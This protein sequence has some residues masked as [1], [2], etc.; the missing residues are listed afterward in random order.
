MSTNLLAIV[1]VLPI[2]VALV[3]MVGLRWGAAKAMTVAWL[4][5]ALAALFVWHLPLLYVS[6]LSLQGVINAISVLIIVFGALLLLHTLQ[7]SGAMETIQYGMQNISKDMRIQAIII[8]YMFSAFVE[9]AAGFGT[10]AALAAPLLFALGFPPLAA[11]ILC[12]TLN[13]FPVTFGA[14]GTP[15]ITG[16][17]A[18]LQ[19]LIE[20]AIEQRIFQSNEHFFEAIG[21]IV[22]LMHIPMIFILPIFTLGFITRFFGPNRSWKDG[23]AAWKFCIF[24]AIAFS[25]P[26]LLVAWL[27]GPEIPS[28]AGG[29]IGL[30]IIMFGAQYGFCVPKEIWTFGKTSKWEK[31]WSGNITFNANDELKP[32]M[33]QFMAWLPYILIGII[34]VLTR[35]DILP[36]KELFNRHGVIFFDDIFGYKDVDE[37]SLK[38][39]Y[40][41]GTIPFM[42]IS[43]LTIFIHRMPLSKAAKAWSETFSKMKTATISLCASVA[44]VKIFQGS[45]NFTNPDLIAQLAK[46]GVNTHILS[47]PR[48]MAEAIAGIVGPIWPLFASYVGGLGSF[49]TGSNTVSDILF[50]QFQWDVAELQKL[51]RVVILAAQGVGGAMGNMICVHNIVAVCAVL[52]LS[53]REGDILKKTFW[54]F[55]LYGLSVGVVAYILIAIGYSTF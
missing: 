46:E 47:M 44:L 10:P 33:S 20:R 40:L 45:G 54:P 1:A 15:I 19:I 9:G 37:G 49:I 8:G 41:P 5:C 4:T 23:F 3:L 34:L 30:S 2:L 7:Y 55:L 50:A 21:Q 14:V 51:S 35:I 28:I 25:V 31:N 36:L 48:V 52:G 22:T 27:V 42:L 16:F 53:N 39:L 6:A 38:L 43:I 26:F 17:G 29:L 32:Q 18:S 13:S 11:A 24:A 12:L